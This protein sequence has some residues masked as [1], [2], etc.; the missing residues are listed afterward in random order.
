[1]RHAPRIGRCWFVTVR[2][3]RRSTA[4]E[5]SRRFGFERIDVSA[6]GQVGG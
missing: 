4:A 1:M 6:P 3:P 5:R 2:L